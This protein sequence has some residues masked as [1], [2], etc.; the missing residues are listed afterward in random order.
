[1]SALHGMMAKWRKD[2]ASGVNT[3][4]SRFFRMANEVPTLLMAGIVILVIVKPF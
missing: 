3:K 1:M 2:L 4:S